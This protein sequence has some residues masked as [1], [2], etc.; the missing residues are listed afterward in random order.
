MFKDMTT[1]DV[2]KLF[3]PL[4]VI[5]LGL[6]IYCVVDIIRKGV[7]NL[8]KIAWITIAL[9]INMIGPIIYLLF[10]RKRWQDD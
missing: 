2:I 8:N 7:R 5:Q 1:I 9:F 10:G 3:A 6:A 4:I